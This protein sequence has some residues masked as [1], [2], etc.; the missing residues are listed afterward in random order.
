MVARAAPWFRSIRV[1][2]SAMLWALRP[3]VLPSFPDEKRRQRRGA[4]R[5]AARWR[6]LRPATQVAG[7]QLPERTPA[8]IISSVVQSPKTAAVQIGN[9]CRFE[10]R[11]ARHRR[12]FHLCVVLEVRHRQHEVIDTLRC[13]AKITWSRILMPDPSYPTARCWWCQ[14]RSRRARFNILPEPLLGNSVSTNSIRRGTL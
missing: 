8:R 14:K 10:R 12:G 6:R 7:F 5:L 11:L 13:W 3:K 1:G 2:V 4:F 9:S